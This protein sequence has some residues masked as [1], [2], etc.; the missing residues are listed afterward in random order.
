MQWWLSL[1]SGSGGYWVILIILCCL[2]VIPIASIPLVVILIVIPIVSIPLV[3]V[4]MVL[5]VIMFFVV[6]S[7]LSLIVILSSLY[8]H[9]SL[10]GP[11]IPVLLLPIST[12]EQLL[13]AAVGGAV[14]MAVVIVFSCHLSFPAIHP[15]HRDSQR[16]CHPYRCVALLSLAPLI[17]LYEQ[18]LVAVVM[19]ACLV[20]YQ[21]CCA[22]LPLSQQGF[23]FRGVGWL[24]MRW[25]GWGHF[26]CLPHGYPATQASWYLHG[27]S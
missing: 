22:I 24:V 16:C 12:C 17:P 23:L 18:R 21:S 9:C 10:A 5:V 4:V 14:V 26:T 11:I 19:R 13:T 27:V 15:A 3:V 2:V 6:L 20:G 7:S 25:Q 1:C 8:P